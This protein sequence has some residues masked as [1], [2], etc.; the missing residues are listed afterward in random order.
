ML[1]LVSCVTSS[2]SFTTPLLATLLSREIR[3]I[4]AQEHLCRHQLLQAVTSW[5][6]L[7]LNAETILTFPFGYGH[8]SSSDLVMVLL[9]I[10]S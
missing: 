9:L 6:L 5:Y 10:L 1:R 8:S 2:V 7:T 3:E 4:E